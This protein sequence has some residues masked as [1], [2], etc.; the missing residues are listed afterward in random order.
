MRPP[1]FDPIDRVT[2]VTK[3]H[4]ESSFA[5]FNRIDGEF[6][7]AQLPISSAAMLPLSTSEPRAT[8]LG[9]LPLLDT[10]RSP[11]NAP[12]A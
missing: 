9:D 3:G 11:A 1:V 8:I 4:E 2:T 5:F 12:A 6:W 7:E 10:G